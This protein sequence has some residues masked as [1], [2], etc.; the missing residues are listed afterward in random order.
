MKLYSRRQ[1]FAA[2]TIAVVATAVA[3]S[4]LVFA[5]T[6]NSEAHRSSLSASSIPASSQSEPSPASTQ[7]QSSS[8]GN[9]AI[10]AAIQPAGQTYSEEELENIGIYEKYNESV[11]NITTEVLSINWFLEPVPQRGGSGSGSI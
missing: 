4:V 11:V 3:A 10:P 1:V 8:T 2:I 9:L 6:R 7:Q 5:L